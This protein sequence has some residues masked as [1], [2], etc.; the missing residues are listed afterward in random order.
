ME[1]ECRYGHMCRIESEFAVASMTG[2]PFT[3]NPVVWWPVP[4]KRRVPDPGESL[5]KTGAT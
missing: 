4:P 2:G 1:E 3:R 5:W